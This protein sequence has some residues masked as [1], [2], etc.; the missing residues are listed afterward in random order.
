MCD[1]SKSLLGIPATSSAV[2]IRRK[3]KTTATHV[4]K[5][6]QSSYFPSTVNCWAK[7]VKEKAKVPKKQQ[8]SLV[9]CWNWVPVRE[10]KVV[11]TNRQQN[12]PGRNWWRGK[13]K[14]ES[15]K[16][17]ITP[18]VETEPQSE[19][20]RSQKQTLNLPQKLEFSVTEKNCKDVDE[21]CCLPELFRFQ[22]RF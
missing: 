9:I 19:R 13:N 22:G 7:V 11:L 20:A 21:K 12:E 15:A 16:E 2:T 3:S 1:R 5:P 4:L 8:H 10:G 18:P 17:S 14:S 6:V